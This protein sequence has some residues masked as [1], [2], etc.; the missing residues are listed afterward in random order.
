MRLSCMPTARLEKML[1]LCAL[2]L[3][4]S[5]D[6]G[7]YGQVSSVFVFGIDVVMWNIPIPVRQ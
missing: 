4:D 2:Y 3:C 5:S 7:G 6:W 1:D